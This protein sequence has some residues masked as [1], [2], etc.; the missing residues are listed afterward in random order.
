MKTRQPLV[1]V[2]VCAHNEEEYVD[3]CLHKLIRALQSF[4]HEIILVA[5]RCTDGTV[6][7]AKRYG[8]KVVEKNL[9]TW[10]NSYAESLQIG[11]REVK[12]THV[13]LIDADIVVPRNFFRDTLPIFKGKV[14][15]VA[16]EVVTY[17]SSTLNSIMHAWEKTRRIA[18]L[19]SEPYG[20]ARV[21]LKKALEHIHGFRD[22]P[23]P[24]TDIDLRLEN[25]GF[26][27]VS[28]PSMQVYHTRQITL[29]TIVN[30]QINSGR[31]RYALKLGFLRTLGHAIFRI[32]PFTIGGWV[33]EWQRRRRKTEPLQCFYV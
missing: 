17:S 12:G 14:A 2:I 13:S 10:E 5:D 7:R 27:S 18:P 16:A 9:S 32:R 22:V 26:K 31:G 15:S 19:G 30:G 29:R 21:I 28:V 33:L 25:A 24:D 3:K 11:F 4:N 8:V 20:A 23:T 1:S 6:E